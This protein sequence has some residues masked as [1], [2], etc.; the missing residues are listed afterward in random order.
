M[1]TYR[2]HA[3]ILFALLLIQ[4][5]QGTASRPTTPNQ[6]V[7]HSVILDM[8]SLESYRAKEASAQKSASAAT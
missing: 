8:T 5:S 3:L 6:V 4:C 1:G 2:Q 7:H